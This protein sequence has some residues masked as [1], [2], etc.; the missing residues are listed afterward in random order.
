MHDVSADL[1]PIFARAGY[2]YAPKAGR[3]LLLDLGPSLTDIRKATRRTWRQTLGYAEKRKLE[4]IE[5]ADCEL[6]DIGLAVHDQMVGRKRFA[7][8]VD[9]R[10]FRVVQALLPDAM[11][12]RI[13]V[14]S[15]ENE[16][17]ATLA[18]SHIGAVGL[19]LIAATAGKALETDAAY[20]LWW[21]MVE[22]LK[23]AGC[24]W[25]D[26]GGINPERNPGGYT[27]KSGLASKASRDVTPLGQFDTGDRI[28][29][30]VI[31]SGAERVR[32]SVRT[33]KVWLE[34]RT[35]SCV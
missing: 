23:A 2:R 20:V 4:I 16:P 28:L 33:L 17:V 24:R 12:L 13:L 6:Y 3:T 14:C 29:S 27:F 19:P 7:E 35:L 10:Q 9:K 11:K 31:V 15:Y 1:L 25:C 26:L 5:G 18:W 32:N 34:K 21:R 22:S 8:F 30:E